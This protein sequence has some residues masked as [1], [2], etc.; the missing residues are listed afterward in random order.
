LATPRL[1]NS[2]I[3]FNNFFKKPQKYTYIFNIKTMDVNKIK[4]VQRAFGGELDADVVTAV[5][6]KIQFSNSDFSQFFI[7]LLVLRKLYEIKKIENDY[8]SWRCL[9]AM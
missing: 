7:I 4:Q 3:F 6:T 2:I 5:V 1:D 9:I 8:Y